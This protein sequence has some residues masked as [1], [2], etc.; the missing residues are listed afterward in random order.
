MS[1]NWT[2]SYAGQLRKVVG[3]QQLIIPS[4]RALIFD[5]EGR[6][7]FIERRG[8]RLWAL[9]AG[10]I[11]LNESI[12][13]CLQREVKEETGL[14]VVE[15]TLIAVYTGTQYTVKTSY[16]DMYQGFEFLYRVDNWQ[17]TLSLETDETRNAAFFALNDPPQIEDG[18]WSEH[19]LEVM[20][21]YHQFN[22]VPFN[23]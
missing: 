1:T 9:P 7:L 14:D 20:N 5:D 11:E 22:G 15:A 12:F 21:D 16:G 18:Y 8:S 10:G 4:I 2:D 23:K 19:H 17:G 6:L 3:H 13:Q